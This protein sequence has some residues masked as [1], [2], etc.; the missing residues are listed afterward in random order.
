MSNTNKAVVDSRLRPRL[1]HGTLQGT[2]QWQH[3]SDRREQ[4]YRKFFK[5][6]LTTLILSSW[7]FTYFLG[8]YNYN[9]IKICKQISTP[10]SRTR[11]YRT[12]I[13]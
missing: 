8:S 1:L 2:N 13:Y 11:K 12:F 6:N 10:P 3:L 9:T 5:I 7:P 4:L